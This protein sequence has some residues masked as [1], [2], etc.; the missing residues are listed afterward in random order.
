M[1]KA[2]PL[3]L[4]GTGAGVVPAATSA[5]EV[6]SILAHLKT[7]AVPIYGIDTAAV[8]PGGNPNYSE[9]ILGEADIAGTGFVLDTKVESRVPENRVGGPL[10][11]ENILWSSKR[12]LERLGVKKV[13]TLYA[14]SPDPTTSV[15]ESVGAFGEVLKAGEADSVRFKHKQSSMSL[16]KF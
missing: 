4:F 16:T 2:A 13:R 6:K 3:I 12:S 15:A 1:T 8:Y 10:T 14:H 9:K 11:K 5:D 7:L